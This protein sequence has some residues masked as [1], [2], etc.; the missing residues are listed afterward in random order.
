MIISFDL[1]LLIPSMKSFP[2]EPQSAVQQLL[3][4]EK[5]RIGTI[6]LFKELRSEGHSIFI[7]TTSFRSPLK[8]KLSFQLYGI[9]ID[10]FINQELHQKNCAR[11]GKSCSKYPPAFGIHL[12]VDDSPGVGMEGLLH[13]FRTIIIRPDD[14]NWV[15][16]VLQEL[17]KN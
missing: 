14:E 10:E 5:I 11:L 4:I 13:N 2:T 8:V 6:D 17:T 3:G 7:Y 15:N 12:H 1:D 16:Q 9:P